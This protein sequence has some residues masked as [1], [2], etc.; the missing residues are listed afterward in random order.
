MQE[1]TYEFE[2]GAKYEGYFRSGAFHGH[3]EMRSRPAPFPTCIDEW[4]T[5]KKRGGRLLT[6]KIPLHGRAYV[7]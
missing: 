2:D 4:R 1:G 7:H 6:S 3:G 5:K